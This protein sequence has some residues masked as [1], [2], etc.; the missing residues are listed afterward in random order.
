MART[1]PRVDGSSLVDGGDGGEPITIG[2]VAWYAW[3]DQATSFA[4]ATTNGSFTARK[5]RSTR[6]GGYW[7]AYRKRAGKLQSAYLGKS[8]DLTLERLQAMA[9]SLGTAAVLDAT[10]PAAPAL[11]RSS[12]SLPPPQPVPPL[13]LMTKLYIPPARPNLVA[14]PLLLERLQAGLLS[15]LTLISAPAG[16]GKTTLLIQALE[17]RNL[18]RGRSRDSHV[19]SSSSAVASVAWVSLDNADRDPARFWSYVLTALDTLCPGIAADALP[20]LQFTPA[21]PIEGLLTQV[22]NALIALPADVVLVLDDYHVIDSI[23]IHA[24]LAFVLE[25]LPP[26]LHLVITT[27]ADPPLPLARLRARGELVELRAAD[28][29]FTPDEV[30]AFFTQIMGLSLAPDEV[31]ALEA[32]T[33]GWIA[34]MQLAALAM[35]D[36]ADH[37]G[38]VAAFTGSNRFVVDYLLAEVLNHLPA[39]LQQFVLQTSILDRLCGP[40]CDAVLGIGDVGLEIENRFSASQSSIFSS[41]T[42]ISGAA[43]SQPLLQELER[44]NLF[45]IPLDNERRWYRYHHLFAEVLRERLHSGAAAKEVLTLHR[46]AC[47]WFEQQA[48]IPEA[49]QHALAGRDWETATRLIEQV[50]LSFALGGKLVT[51]LDWFLALPDTH[52]RAHPGLCIAHAAALFLANQMDLCDARLQ[53]AERQAH[54]AP[55]ERQAG[56][57]LG[58]VA[59]IRGNMARRTGDIARCIALSRQGLGQLIGSTTIAEASALVNISRAYELSGDVSPT[60]EQRVREAIT[61]AQAVGS[62]FTHLHALTTLGRLQMLQGRLRAAA[63]TFRETEQVIGGAPGM[64]S[65]AA[66]IGLGTLHLVWNDLDAAERQLIPAMDLLRISL[67]EDADIIVHG[68]LAFADVLQ[69]LGDHSGARSALAELSEVAQQR[70]VWPELGAQVEVARAWLA[71]RQG[72]LAFAIE[73]A[74]RSRLQTDD[75]VLYIHTRAYLTL[76]RVRIAQGQNTPTE[77]FLAD[78][79]HLLDRLEVAA[80][81]DGRMGDMLEIRVLRALA[82]Q[83]EDNAVAA[84][85]VLSQALLF[86]EAEGYVR[87]FIDEGAPMVELLRQIAAHRSSVGAYAAT[88]LEAFPTQDKQPASSR[89]SA[90]ALSSSHSVSLPLIEPL[91]NREREILHLVAE[92]HSNQTIADRLVVAVSTVKKHVNNIYGKLDVQSRTQALARARELNLL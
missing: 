69:T 5:E 60:S 70:T 26:C 47:A 74:D 20:S 2:T 19:S 33:E 3:L 62:V 15:K 92:G 16:F 82:F 65:L 78:V 84:L 51:V 27:R 4:V 59:V 30:A 87:I 11:G 76:A 14:R 34:G 85:R 64:R 71:L 13:L 90:I 86:A 42:V 52:V 6:A 17:A 43:Y 22:L 58:P 68:Y 72:D 23:A 75:Q 81:A 25:H 28:L 39:H 48:L 24:A 55:S 57:I 77:P 91:S 40:L 50:G 46:C 9:A 18:G 37:A 45:V 31:A 80:E 10:L 63:A 73:W 12:D 49:I 61:T 66:N 36:R 21:P 8:A 56:M 54:A 53:D 79:L 35:R 44:V 83:A 41:Q 67:A 89:D 32:R 1:T 29:R 38:F 88:L 7:K